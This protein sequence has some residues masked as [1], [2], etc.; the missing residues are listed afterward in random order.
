VAPR[1]LSAAAMR[2]FLCALAPSLLLLAC[3]GTQS[4]PAP[5]APSFL[6]SALDTT[7]ASPDVV[8]VL[9][10]VLDARDG[11]VLAMDGVEGSAHD[12]T[13]PARVRRSHG[14]VGKTFTYA[15][16]LDRGAI[17]LADQFDGAPVSIAGNVVEDHETHLSMS[18]EDGMAFS[19]NVAAVHVLER[20]GRGDLITGLRALR[21]DAAI[22]ATAGEDELVAARLAYGPALEATPLE[23]ASAFAAV[24]NGGVYHAPW[25]EGEEPT[26]PERVLS[27]EAS[28]SMR[29]LLEAAVTRDDATGHRAQLSATRVGGKTGTMPLDDG[30]THGCFAGAFP[31]DDPRFVIVVDVVTR[32]GGYSG[33]TIAAPAFARIAEGWLESGL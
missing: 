21:L 20:L 8:S 27:P 28:S 14:S 9:A 30:G 3:G 25:R 15:I 33:G 5:A 4:P 23:I 22:P 12:A 10:V 24:V 32:G 19:S 1:V 31:I 13:L 17:T 29:A 7:A 26:A 18:V 2:T 11:Q 6:V 16:A